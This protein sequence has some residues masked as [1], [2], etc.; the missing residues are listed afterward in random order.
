MNLL[1]NVELSQQV[2]CI[3]CRLRIQM[4]VMVAS[5]KKMDT[6]RYLLN[7]TYLM[8]FIFFLLGLKI[9]LPISGL[10]L[11]API[12]CIILDSSY[13][14]GSACGQCV[15][16]PTSYLVSSNGSRAT[17]LEIIQST[18]WVIMKR[19]FWNQI[20]TMASLSTSKAG[21]TWSS[22]FPDMVPLV[23]VECKADST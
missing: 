16:I 19:K 10:I 8:Y 9:I 5:F 1:C 14:I 20:P 12:T 6:L 2:W 21:K 17:L 7:L 18:F 13:L 11:G 4:T 15:I 3:P 23:E 22:D